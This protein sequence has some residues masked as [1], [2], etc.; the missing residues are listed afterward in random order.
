M[1]AWAT[2]PHLHVHARRLAAPRRQHALSLDL[3]RQHRR[4]DGALSAT[5]SSTC[6]A[7]SRRRWRKASSIPTSEVP[8][9]GASGAISGVLGAYILL[10][11]GATVRVFI[12]LGIF[13]T[14]D[15]RPG[16]D[17]A[18]GLVP[19][20]ALQRPSPRRH[21][22]RAAWRSGRMSA[23]SSPGAVLICFFKSAGSSCWRSP[24]RRPSTSSAAAGPGANW[25][26][27]VP[28]VLLSLDAEARDGEDAVPSTSALH[29]DRL[30]AIQAGNP[31]R[32]KEWCAR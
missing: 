4:F 8:M 20:A 17:R 15:A 19:D 18:R 13:V 32:N 30:P 9:V 5:P 6:C 21:R 3:R 27:G 28:A 16:A 11:P 23:A 24:A 29:R 31:P 26:D 7:G 14:V 22:R 25:R 2:D 1:P 10:H 12:F